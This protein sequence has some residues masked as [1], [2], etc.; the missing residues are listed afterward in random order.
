MVYGLMDTIQNCEAKTGLGEGPTINLEEGPGLST[1]AQFSL[2]KVC[3]ISEAFDSGEVWIS[4]AEKEGEDLA[5][6]DALQN[7][8]KANDVSF[9]G[10]RQGLHAVWL[11]SAVSAGEQGAVQGRTDGRT[12]KDGCTET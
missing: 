11:P 3:K 7:A 5:A 9:A 12:A 2:N 1:I 10:A 8:I 4:S 6:D